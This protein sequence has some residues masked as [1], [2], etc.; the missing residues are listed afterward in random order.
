MKNKIKNIFVLIL[1]LI[2]PFKVNAYGFCK[3][4]DSIRLHKLANNVLANYSYY[5]VNGNLRFK[6][7]IYNLNPDL[8]I[9]DSAKRKEITAKSEITIDNYGAG[10]SIEYKI[11]SNLN[12]C[13]GQYISSLYVTLP[14][15]N[16]YYKD[17]LCK[18]LETYTLCRRWAKVDLTYDQFKKQMNDYIDYLKQKNKPNN[19]NNIF[20]MI[21]DFYIK[22][23]YIILPV[24]IV[25]GGAILL[26]IKYRE[27]KEE[28]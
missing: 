26:I 4:E 12:Y 15:Y 14:S 1:L 6:I 23:Y 25:I 10:K 5:E 22:Y 2:L 8:Y 20:Q 19:S 11:Y 9:Y 27:E 18:G 28:F 7:N 24:I 21:L 16:P 17:E 3:T 13:K